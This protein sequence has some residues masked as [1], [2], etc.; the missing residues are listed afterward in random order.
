MTIL[1]FEGVLDLYASTGDSYHLDTIKV[2]DEDV[3]TAVR[4]TDFGE[5]ITVAFASAAWRA[6]FEGTGI[7]ACQSSRGYSEWTP[8]SPSE[9]ELFFNPNNEV[10]VPVENCHNI[11]EE[12][13]EFDGKEVTIWI[14]DEPVNVLE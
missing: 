3:V 10:G 13:R 11:K 4:N 12:L 2:G 7:W 14:A 9:L 8:G 1:K 6:E 5:R